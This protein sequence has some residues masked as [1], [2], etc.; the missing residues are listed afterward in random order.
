M[1]NKLPITYSSLLSARRNIFIR[2]ISALEFI[3]CQIKSVGGL[4]HLKL[5]RKKHPISLTVGFRETTK[6]TKIKE[7]KICLP[8]TIY[9][10]KNNLCKK[11]IPMPYLA[12]KK[13]SNNIKRISEKLLFKF[14]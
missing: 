3:D 13:Q 11:I 14:L 7:S 6:Q 4:D 1:N 2:N 12:H 10:S 9:L 8:I 5:Q